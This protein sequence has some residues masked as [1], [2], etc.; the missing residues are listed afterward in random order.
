MRVLVVA[1]TRA[2]VAPLISHFSNPIAHNRVLSG[3]YGPHKVDV[4]LTGVGMVA[5]AVWAAATSRWKRWNTARLPLS[6]STLHSAP[7]VA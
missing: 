2:E 5:T 3:V 7:D 1:A 6:L 4:L